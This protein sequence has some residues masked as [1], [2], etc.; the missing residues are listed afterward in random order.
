MKKLTTNPASIRMAP[1]MK[2]LVAVPP[3]YLLASAAAWA[4]VC[5]VYVS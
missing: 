4:R 5:V 3:S 1:M 2:A